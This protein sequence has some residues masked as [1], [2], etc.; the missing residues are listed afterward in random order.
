M[1]ITDY[2]PLWGLETFGNKLVVGWRFRF[3]LSLSAAMDIFGR[4]T[5]ESSKHYVEMNALSSG[6]NGKPSFSYLMAF[7]VEHVPYD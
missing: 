5:E 4:A 2:E 7:C 1:Q 3:R 6:A